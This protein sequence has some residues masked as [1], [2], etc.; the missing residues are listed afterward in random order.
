MKALAEV[1]KAAY[2]FLASVFLYPD[3]PR[4][5]WLRRASR[6]FLTEPAFAQLAFF[7][8]W[9]PLLERLANGRERAL[10]QAYLELFEAAGTSGAC[11]L[12]ASAY[13]ERAPGMLLSELRHQYL[14]AGLVPAGG[15][16]P[17][18]LAVALEYMSAL[19]GKEQEAWEQDELRAGD[20]LRREREFLER[21]LQPWVPGL[22]AR[23]RRCDA[24]GVYTAGADA[25]EEFLEHEVALTTV[26]ENP[27]A[28]GVR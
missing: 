25:L 16:Y 22:C 5:R 3:A 1:R 19:V 23:V 18:H 8:A 15:Q 11:S 6:V 4:R 17:D 7:R 12:C 21:Y 28:V 24:T 10:E 2:R 26:L 14:E 20:V 27:G 9:L 13:L